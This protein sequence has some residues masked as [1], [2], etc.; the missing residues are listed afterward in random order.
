[1]AAS[2]ASSAPSS[3]PPGLALSIARVLDG[4]TTA[5]SASAASQQPLLAPP[6]LTDVLAKRFATPE[7]LSQDS[8]DG[9]QA[10]LRRRLAAID[11][12]NDEL[13]RQL[14][15]ILSH[16]ALGEA[17]HLQAAV[18]TLV[19]ELDVIREKAA[20]SE[21]SVREITGEMRSLD[22]AKDNLV[23]SMT[24]LRR[25]QMLESGATRLEKLTDDGNF[26]EAAQALLATK[27]L[28]TSFRS[29]MGV[30]RVSVV[31]RR[32]TDSQQ[33]LKSAA[34][35]Q[36]EKF[37][38][39]G[40]GSTNI[41]ATLIPEAA[42]TLDAIGGEALTSLL[43][44][45]CSLQLRE[46]RRIF[47]ATDEAGQ[48]DNVSRR[49]AWFRRVL[50]QHDEEHADGFLEPWKTSLALTG[51]F[52][53]ITREDIKSVLLRQRA[54]LQVTTLLEALQAT[55][56]F[57]QQASKRFHVPFS[58]ILAAS[59]KAASGGSSGPTGISVVTPSS[60]ADDIS[61][62]YEPFLGLFV[63]AQDKALAELMT[64]FRRQGATIQDEHT[65][66]EA[67]SQG[68]AGAR[69]SHTVLPSSTELF[70]FY[71]QTLE[72]CAK[73]SNREPFRDLFL[74]FRRYLRAY[75]DEV[76][77]ASL[78]G[79]TEAS[80]RR[81][82]STDTRTN[83]QDLAKWCLVL[84]T[85]D[86]CAN[87]C[88]Q[89]EQRLKDKIHADFKDEVTL[90]PNRELFASIA[91][92][93]IQ[94]LTREAELAMEPSLQR[95]MR[96]TGGATGSLPW[97]QLVEV[98]GKSAYVDDIR[99]ALD[100]IAIVVRSDIETRRYVRTWSDRV[101]ALLT[102][103]FV[104]CTVRIRPIS[105]VMAEQLLVD[106]Y[107]LKS[108]LLEL[109]QYTPSE[110]SSAL[111]SS[112]VRHV[113]RSVDRA[114]S[115]LRAVM[116]PVG[117]DAIADPRSRESFVREYV[118]LV[119]DRSLS[120]FQ[121]VLELKGLAGRRTSATQQQQL[122]DALVETFIAV[123]HDL[124]P[125]EANE[126]SFLTSLDMDP[127]GAIITPV[128]NIDF[129]AY[130]AQVAPVGAG[131]GAGGHNTPPWLGYTIRSPD[132]TGARSPLGQEHSGVLSSSLA[133]LT[134]AGLGLG[135]V[136]GGGGA[137][138]TGTSSSGGGFGGGAG[139]GSGAASG[140]AG[141]GAN[142]PTGSG[143]TPHRVFGAGG[144]FGSLF[145]GLGMRRDEN[146]SR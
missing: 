48:L 45:Y 24:A 82:T 8:L 99:A 85:A 75:A 70:Y 79:R 54:K 71:R 145:G 72:Q 95:M 89:L 34:M 33:K 129:A 100:S 127:S 77:R 39:Q 1:M 107:E 67:A 19:D 108:L 7:S 18:R 94:T 52:S 3:L 130:D 29:Y 91:S 11:D 53:E 114:E 138:A 43:D 36:Y 120:N 57:E 144:K 101:V 73:L 84:N 22:T 44:W 23:S 4:P 28:Q 37:F 88:Q 98:H 30:E 25:L 137:S 105:R 56:D 59:P 58:Q 16:P 40:N 102:L 47:R 121:K 68:A 110:S 126:T 50:K 139:S 78:S 10:L 26:K 92:A 113:E 135:L 131:T 146:R 69:S 55:T 140:G 133:N 42:L 117:L 134:A 32:I 111:G 97:S 109:P 41:G 20:A 104:Q 27:E 15:G 86:Y 143:T 63:E 119:G 14:D 118:Q 90:E 106:L 38:L 61:S 115:L 62:V 46:Y 65:S 80:S 60:A 128:P 96:P 93:S 136:G 66:G 81:S 125:D 74:V 122:S 35:E 21:S 9:Y 142:T 87:T 124:A 76:L 31:W 103:K 12:E 6:S 83:T 132:R 17:G 64:T 2:S 13:M 141:T 123:T 51:R 5:S 49:F 112:Y 116:M